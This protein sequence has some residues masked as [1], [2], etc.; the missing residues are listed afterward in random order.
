MLNIKFCVHSLSPLM[1]VYILLQRACGGLHVIL[2]LFSQF[3]RTTYHSACHNQ[4]VSLCL[5]HRI[6]GVGQ[7]CWYHLVKEPLKLYKIITEASM[8]AVHHVVSALNK[9][10][11]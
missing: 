1:C 3:V 6:F 9:N 4:S 8:T 10:N 11:I 5:F 2:L 7:S